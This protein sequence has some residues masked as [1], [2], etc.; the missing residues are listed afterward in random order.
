MH[1][2]RKPTQV[3]GCSCI[4]FQAKSC[5]PLEF[6]TTPAPEDLFLLHF[7]YMHLVTVP[8]KPAA[9]RPQVYLGSCS[10]R[11]HLSGQLSDL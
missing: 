5:L 6:S 11:A 9:A 3:P 1:I 10:S 7:Q 2:A 8:T 4:V